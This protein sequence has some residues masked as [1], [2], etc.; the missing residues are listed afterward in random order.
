MLFAFSWMGMGNTESFQQ[1]RVLE[2]GSMHPGVV[3]FALGDGSVRSISETVDQDGYLYA[4]GMQ[5]GRT[6]NIID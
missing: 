5:E 4:T 6:H 1:S 2:H 3:Q